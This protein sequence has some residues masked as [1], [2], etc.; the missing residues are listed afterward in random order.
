MV[1]G[2]RLSFLTLLTFRA[3][4]AE[5]ATF[6][7]RFSR[8][9]TRLRVDLL[10]NYDKV[11]PPESDR[12]ENYSGAGTDVE[13]Q[14]NFFKVQGVDASTG[15]MRLK[16]W[17]RM[18]W[19][20]QR[21]SWDPAEYG[22]IS[23]VHFLSRHNTDRENSEIWLPDIQLWNAN[24]GT[25]LSLDTTNAVVQSSGSVF[26]SRPGL[27][28]TL[29]KFS[30]LVAFPFDRLKC[31]ME[32]GGWTFSGGFQGIEL[33]GQGYAESTTEDTAGS[34][35]QEYS[36]EAIRIEK[37]TNFYPNFPSEPWTLVKYSI[38]LSRASFYYW[39]LIIFPTVLITYLS[40]GVFFMSHEVGERLSFGITL[41]LVVEV[42]KGTVATFVPVCGELLWIDLFMLINTIFCCLSLIET[43]AV[44]FF[45]FHM[46]DH[47]LPAWLAWLAPWCL[48][49][50][51]GSNIA[52]SN[53]GRIYRQLNR[54]HSSLLR[55]SASKL[56]KGNRL[57]EISQGKLSETDTAKLIFF[58]NLFY[59]LDSDSNGLITVDEAACMLSFVNLGLSRTMLEEILNT[60]WSPKVLFDCG[61]FLEICLELMWT[62]P[63]QEIKLGAENY[64]CS[65][66]RH[67]KRCH[68]YWLEWSKAVDKWSRFWLPLLYTT[69]LGFLLN[70]DM[71]DS[72]DSMSGSV[73]FQ[74]LGPIH[75]SLP[76][77]IQALVSP[78][79]GLVSLFTWVQMRRLS[80]K[81]KR[82]EKA[83]F[84]AMDE[85]PEQSSRPR[86]RWTV[87]AEDFLPPGQDESD[88][89]PSDDAS[90][91]TN[92][93]TA[94]ENRSE[95]SVT[96]LVAKCIGADET[97]TRVN[98]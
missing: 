42:M 19:I 11:V 18:G 55:E 61:D 87:R 78:A 28:D 93:P 69:A 57:Q 66:N 54:E 85:A 68:T 40:F 33:M 50:P 84:A 97:T 12:L 82:Q 6:T 26:W 10:Q 23:Q 88:A 15:Q 7:K 51:E 27:L 43:M 81:W 96:K 36:I 48:C 90:F 14:I 32:W 72:Y 35:Y 58:E 17:V 4:R 29:C 70:L 3:L 74:G 83:A 71:R 59:L 53:A 41:L 46:D 52:E 25:E 24:V 67:T 22:N 2:L 91:E 65:K 77:V 30:G 63:F 47:F 76:G 94:D 56:T 34:S 49:R 5:D 60:A 73:M 89:V 16:V 38:T 62:T 95:G 13:M 79:I 31:S 39:L 64:I 1:P 37:R 20:D 44:L 92:N 9:A 21:L 75:M 86:P 98:M 8:E 80:T 45:A